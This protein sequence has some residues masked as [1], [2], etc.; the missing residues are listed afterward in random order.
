[1]SAFPLRSIGR[2]TWS[3]ARRVCWTICGDCVDV[4][5][6]RKNGWQLAE[7][8]GDATPAWGAASAVH[9][10]H[11]T[12]RAW[13]RGDLA[14]Y[15]A[16]MQSGQL[17]SPWSLVV[18]LE[19]GFLKKG[20]KSA[21]ALGVGSVSTCRLRSGRIE[22]SQIGVCPGLCLRQSAGHLLDRRTV[23][24]SSVCDGGTCRAAAES[25]RG[26]LRRWYSGPTRLG[27]WRSV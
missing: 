6:E 8:A 25:F 7:R 20:D 1:M 19:T 5:V 27:T 23:P 3:R 2:L 14:G 4:P 21:W 11:G 24:D 12:A 17:L 26:A 13:C 16:S 9:L 18:E 15:V 22:N 10:R